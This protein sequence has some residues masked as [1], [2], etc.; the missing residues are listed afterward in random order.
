MKVFVTGGAG[1]IGS[2]MTRELVHSGYDVTVFDAMYFGEE[3]LD[4]VKDQIKIIKGDIR[5]IDPKLLEGQDAVIDFA[6]IPNDPVG[7]LAPDYTNSVNHIGRVGVA[8]ISKQ[9]GVKKYIAP[10]SAGN[11]GQSKEPVTEESPVAP[12]TIYTKAN[13]AWEQEILPMHDK[14]F[15]VTVLRQSTVFGVSPRMRF[16]II[17]ND[18][19]LQAWRDKKIR[20]KGNG[21]EFRPFVHLQDDCQA[22]LKVLEA[23]PDVIN[24]EIF[25]VGRLE[26]SIRVKD[27]IKII[28]DTLGIQIAVE[29]GEMVDKRDYIMDCSKIERTLGFKARYSIPDGVR[30]IYKALEDGTLKADDPRTITLKQYKMLIERGQLLV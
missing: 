16:D 3:K 18:F 15:C 19:T 8:R 7:E 28:T 25:N 30:E 22:F 13:H 21:M 24:G 23:D 9:K 2:I 20:I 6:A 29:M 5:K 1:Y 26:N 10:S 4:E 14:N 12:I 17:V 11:Y 27:V